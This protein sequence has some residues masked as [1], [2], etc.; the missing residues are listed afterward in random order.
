MAQS[1]RRKSWNICRTMDYRKKVR[2]S[3]RLYVAGNVLFAAFALMSLVL[4]VMVLDRVHFDL[5]SA[6]II[7]PIGGAL[8]LRE[9]YK[10]LRFKAVL[11]EDFTPVY[12]Q[13]LPELFALLDEVCG[14]LSLSPV[15]RVYISGGAEAAVFVQ[16][17]LVNLFRRSQ[18]RNLV[19]GRAFL[20][21]LDDDELRA[22]LYHEFGHYVQ[23]E[24][25]DTSYVYIVG[26][27]SRSFLAIRSSE[28]KMSM[29]KI[30]TRSQLMLF[31]Y[32]SLWICVRIDKAYSVLSRQME[33][34]ADDVAVRYAGASVLCRALSHASAVRYNYDF[35]QWGLACL[36]R[37]GLTVSCR[38]LFQALSQLPGDVGITPEV[39][40]RLGRLGVEARN[41]KS[42]SVSDTGGDTVRT[43]VFRI[44]E[45][46]PVPGAEDLGLCSEDEFAAWLLEGIDAYKRMREAARSVQVEVHLGRRRHRLPY[47][48]GKYAVLLDG[49]KVGMGNFI[50]GYT[51][52][53]R[54][55][56]GRH[57]LSVYAF[58][59]ILAVPF[60]FEAVHGG[61]YRI[62][63]D[64]KY[65]FRATAYKVFVEST[66]TVDR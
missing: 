28:E 24:I 14:N 61:H 31:S 10:A 58:G 36:R 4:G 5:P 22:V 44:L 11:P 1:R 60:E 8:L 40:R 33:Y 56:P 25:L 47:A 66:D 29:W 3:V 63:M 39:R 6:W 26:Q 45:D 30:Q 52:R 13:E 7:F 43:A 46:R 37:N 21:Q 9:M 20:T 49:R 48:E 55:S 54:T 38:G 27:L 12:R 51:L 57:V 23:E 41:I 16:P 2:N 34:A 50:K 59:G 65:V 62:E 64:Y 17:A 53:L 19:I 35:A 15:S 18:Q 32:F 42:V